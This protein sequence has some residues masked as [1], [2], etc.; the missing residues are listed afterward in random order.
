MRALP[1]GLDETSP[2]FSIAAAAELA[3]LHAR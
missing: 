1:A 3:G 2:I